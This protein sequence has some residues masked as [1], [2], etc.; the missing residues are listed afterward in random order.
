MA[1][2]PRHVLP[3]QGTFHLTARGAGKIAIYLDDFDRRFFLGLFAAAVERN[4]LHVHT[5]CLMTN[6]YHLVVEA[7]RDR[8]STAL[9]A[10]NGVYAQRFNTRH[11]RWGHLFGERFS[12]WVVRSE[13]HLQATCH[14]VM[15][16]P[17]RAGLCENIGE[18]PWARS[19]YDPDS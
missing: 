1:R 14:Y 4:E 3:E 5:L 15:A 6:H 11:D 12:A 9:H 10:V 8:I 19:R 17:V 7:G 13:K 16:N 2:L 18:W